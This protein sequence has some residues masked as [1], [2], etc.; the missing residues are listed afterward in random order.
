MVIMLQEMEVLFTLWV[1]P[2]QLIAK[3]L[4]QIILLLKME[5]CWQ[6][7]VI[8]LL[9]LYHLLAIPRF[10]ATTVQLVTIPMVEGQFL[11]TMSS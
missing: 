5:E 3:L 6:L 7:T 4:S 11:Q 1:V 8:L 2:L 9:Q 10:I